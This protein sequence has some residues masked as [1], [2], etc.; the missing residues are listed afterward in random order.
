V[1][2]RQAWLTEIIGA[3]ATAAA[4]DRL[5]GVVSDTLLAY[6]TAG[7][8]GSLSDPN[9]V[10]LALAEWVAGRSYAAIHDLLSRRRVRVSR[11]N[12][13]IEDVVALRENGLGYDVA[14]VVASLADLAEPLDSTLQG[15]LALLQRQVK[16]GLTETAALAFLEAGFADRVVAT[17]LGQAWPRV[18]ERDGMRAVCRNEREAVQV[19]L[20]GMPAYFRAVAAEL[21]A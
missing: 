14:M 19:I 8:I 2:D 5:L 18:R 17:A 9:V 10:P 13:T 11:N 15:A 4:E 16:N 6:T 7:S 3:L 12:A 1:A 20:D 21:R